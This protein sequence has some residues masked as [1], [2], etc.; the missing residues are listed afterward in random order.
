M[1]VSLSYFLPPVQDRSVFLK[2]DV[3][4]VIA[5][6]TETWTVNVTSKTRASNS[7]RFFCLVRLSFFCLLIKCLHFVPFTFFLTC[8]LQIVNECF[9][10]SD[11]GKALTGLFK[12]LASLLITSSFLHWS[13]WIPVPSGLV[14]SHVDTGLLGPHRHWRQWLRFCAKFH[15]L[16]RIALELCWSRELK[17]SNVANVHEFFWLNHK[18]SQLSTSGLVKFADSFHDY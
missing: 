2:G 7:S 6:S 8:L 14:T 13:L 4:V 9:P 5:E 11:R 12:S 3:I 16:N 1:H 10:R 15:V 18:E 17:T